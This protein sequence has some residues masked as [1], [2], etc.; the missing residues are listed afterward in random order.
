ML[1]ENASL[2]NRAIDTT[3]LDEQREHLED[4]CLRAARRVQILLQA[5]RMEAIARHEA[6]ELEHRKPQHNTTNN[7]LNM[8]VA[9]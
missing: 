6:F 2:R 7:A 5:M 4:S 9:H 8:I 1:V 3:G